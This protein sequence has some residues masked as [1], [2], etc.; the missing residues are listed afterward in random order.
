MAQHWYNIILYHMETISIFQKK[1]IDK[2]NGNEMFQQINV[3]K[4]TGQFIAMAADKNWP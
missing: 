3:W 2:G 1:K 4:S